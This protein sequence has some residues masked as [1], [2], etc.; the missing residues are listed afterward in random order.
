MHK[1]SKHLQTQLGQGAIRDPT[2]E[3]KCAWNFK[4][5][6]EAPLKILERLLLF[7]TARESLTSTDMFYVRYIYL[8]LNKTVRVTGC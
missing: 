3:G 4:T 7:I 1:E 2:G 5:Y 8:R 6:F